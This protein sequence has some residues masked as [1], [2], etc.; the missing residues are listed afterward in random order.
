[1]DLKKKKKGWALKKRSNSDT[2]FK[3]R[4]ATGLFDYFGF[5]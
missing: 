3:L 4:G 1:M 2:S 5:D